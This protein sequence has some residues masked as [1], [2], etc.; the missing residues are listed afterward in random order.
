MDADVDAKTRA[1]AMCEL[2]R[3]AMRGHPGSQ[4][5]VDGAG[6][7]GMLTILYRDVRWLE[8]EGCVRVMG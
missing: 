5:R 3:I 6:S 1:E 2:A 7:C 8:E 4:R